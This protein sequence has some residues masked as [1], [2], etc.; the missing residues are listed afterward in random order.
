MTSQEF[1]NEAVSDIRITRSPAKRFSSDQ[2][3]PFGTCIKTDTPSG[4]SSGNRDTISFSPGR[5]RRRSFEEIVLP[6]SFCL[7][8]KR[9]SDFSTGK[10]PFGRIFL[11]LVEGTGTWRCTGK[12]FPENNAGLLSW[13]PETLGLMEE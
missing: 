4:E 2:R 5:A 6:G 9:V 1:A 10:V 13:R 11:G 12:I 7:S 8:E 3:R